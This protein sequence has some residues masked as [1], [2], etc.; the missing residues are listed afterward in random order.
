MK[1]VIGKKNGQDQVTN[2]FPGCQIC[3]KAFILCSITWPFLMLQFKT[4]WFFLQNIT[5]GNLYKPFHDV[6]I[7]SFEMF[8]FETIKFDQGTE[9]F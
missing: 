2:S 4:V 7:I 6:I 9:N 1:F 5:I 8:S 3:S